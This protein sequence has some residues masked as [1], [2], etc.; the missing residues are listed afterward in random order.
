MTKYTYRVYFTAHAIGREAFL[1]E[2]IV[3]PLSKLFDD[4]EDI[5]RINAHMAIEML[6]ESPKGLY[7]K[8][9]MV[10]TLDISRELTWLISLFLQAQKEL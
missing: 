5:A 2:D 8:L 10:S 1:R 4:K 7:K 9:H 3:L 6:S